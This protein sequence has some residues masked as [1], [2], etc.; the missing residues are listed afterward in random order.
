MSLMQYEIYC[1]GRLPMQVLYIAYILSTTKNLFSE[2][3]C[4]RVLV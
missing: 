1:L 4:A 3:F 2:E